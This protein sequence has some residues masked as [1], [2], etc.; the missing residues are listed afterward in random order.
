MEG[1]S[2]RQDVGHACSRPKAQLQ[3][4]CGRWIRTVLAEGAQLSGDGRRLDDG[5]RSG[6]RRMRKVLIDGG[7]EVVVSSGRTAMMSMW[8]IVCCRLVG[9]KGWCVISQWIGGSGA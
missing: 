4:V 2:Y 7:Q 8:C 1:A 9:L 6:K 3:Y 5:K